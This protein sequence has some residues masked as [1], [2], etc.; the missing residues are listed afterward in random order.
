[1]KIAIY[2][3]VEQAHLVVKSLRVVADALAARGAPAEAREI[4]DIGT[5]FYRATFTVATRIVVQLTEEQVAMVTSSLRAVRDELAEQGTAS[6]LVEARKV[7]DAL[8]VFGGGSTRR[9]TPTSS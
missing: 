5:A 8:A 7:D 2:L 1:M 4:D 3:T 9:W 6:A